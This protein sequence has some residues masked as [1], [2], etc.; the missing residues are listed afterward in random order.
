[1]F[2]R[3][4]LTLLFNFSCFPAQA[5]LDPLVALWYQAPSAALD[6]R[7]PVLTASSSGFGDSG[8][9][10]LSAEGNAF[11]AS[12]ILRLFRVEE[13]LTQLTPSKAVER[14]VVN[15]RFNLTASYSGWEASLIYRQLYTAVARDGTLRVIRAYTARERLS[16]GEALALDA[17]LKLFDMMG[18]SIARS[19]VFSAGENAG[20]AIFTT[21]THAQSVRSYASF[22]SAGNVIRTGD[23]FSFNGAAD[24][25]DSRRRF[26]GYGDP[27]TRGH[28]VGLDLALAWQLDERRS[29]MLSVVNALSRAQIAEVASQ[30]AQLTSDTRF[31]SSDGYLVSQ[32]SVDGRYSA[33]SY[34]FELPR[35]YTFAFAANSKL[36]SIWYGGGDPSV[37]LPIS[38]GFRLQRIGSLSLQTAWASLPISPNC[39][40]TT[41]IEF[42]FDSKGIGLNCLWGQLMIRSNTGDLSNAKSLGVSFSMRQRLTF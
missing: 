41:E 40:V 2:G 8:N 31:V 15:A 19:W 11:A 20:K 38:S 13:S 28:S 4:C 14:G 10:Y 34:R 35:I 7:L 26:E 29:M 25:S 3:I 9:F 27:R 12:K 30:S 24:L 18:P 23:D 22:K 39:Q 33:E 36:P 6:H 17:Q 42:K 5:G 32:P 1:M 16:N 21:A 37:G